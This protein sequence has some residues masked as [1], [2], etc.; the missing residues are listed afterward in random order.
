MGQCREVGWECCVYG[1]RVVGS[2]KKGRLW[3]L[4]IRTEP[5]KMGIG[6]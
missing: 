1:S 4:E 3:A 5:L 2:I 6:L